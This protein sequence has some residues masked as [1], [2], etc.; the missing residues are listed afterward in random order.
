MKIISGIIAFIMWLAVIYAILNTT[1]TSH[2][3]LFPKSK[4]IDLNNTN[5][6]E[7]GDLCKAS[8]NSISST[9]STSSTTFIKEA[10]KIE[11][12]ESTL[13]SPKL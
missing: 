12:N 11:D 7:Y 6:D 2:E 1:K 3:I 9:S 5:V 10:N 4:R 8:I 13:L